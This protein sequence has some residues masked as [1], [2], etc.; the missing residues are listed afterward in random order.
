MILPTKYLNVRWSLL[1]VGAQILQHLATARTVTELWSD[2]QE[3]PEVTSFERF[4]LALALLY[5]L[6]LVELTE[7]GLLEKRRL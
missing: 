1:A 4:T 2:V 3:L 5:S 7:D 6:G